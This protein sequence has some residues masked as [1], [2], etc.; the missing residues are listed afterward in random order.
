MVS[1]VDSQQVQKQPL[2]KMDIDIGIDD[3]SSIGPVASDP[4]EKPPS[5]P[6]AAPEPKPIRLFHDD[7]LRTFF[8]RISWSPDGRLLF[9]PCGMLSQ[10]N[11]LNLINVLRLQMV[12][13]TA[14]SM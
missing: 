10:G 9:A 6:D 8:R 13:K 4:S 1:E 11:H 7:G 14:T 5:N 2:D 12:T 3:E